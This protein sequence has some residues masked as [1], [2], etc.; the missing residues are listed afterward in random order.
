MTFACVLVPLQKEKERC[1]EFLTTFQVGNDKVGAGEFKYR[2]E[3]AA[4]EAGDILRF[5]VDLDDVKA[6]DHQLAD[7][8]V[9]NTR[10]YVDLF[11]AALDELLPGPSRNLQDKNGSIQD[12]IQTAR[13]DRLASYSS[14]S[15][16]SSGAGGDAGDGGG[17]AGAQPRNFSYAELAAIFP[18]KLLRKYEVRFHPLK[19]ASDAPLRLR[20]IGSTSIG[21]FVT[22]ECMVIRAT[23]VKPLIEVA[24]YAW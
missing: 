20:D 15:S 18:P 5:Q 12:T 10:R 11:S 14:S 1:K 13:L 19:E 3:L 21:K 2:T 7:S 17:P 9:K 24:V 23:D 6:F 4:L 22:A 16:S 8:I